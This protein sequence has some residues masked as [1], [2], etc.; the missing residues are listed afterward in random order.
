MNPRPV[1]PPLAAL[2]L[3]GLLGPVLPASGLAADPPV[4][5][6]VG[7]P[8]DP[9]AGTA[10]GAP[11]AP[12]PWSDRTSV[13]A[14][15]DASGAPDALASGTGP[16]GPRP[17]AGRLDAPDLAAHVRRGAALFSRRFTPAD[18]AGRPLAT[19]AIVPTKRRR[20]PRAEYART[21]GLD[22]NACASCHAEPV[23]GGAGDFSANVFVSEGF[24]H[25]DFDTTDPQFSNERNTNHLF[26]AGLVELLAREMSAE[27]Q[28]ARDAA[29][30]GARAAGAPVGA[31]LAAKGVDFGT[32]TAHPDGTLDVGDVDGVDADLVVRP[33]SHKGVMTSLR[34]FTVNALNHHHGVQGVERF[35]ARWTGETDFDEDGRADE[36]G[37]ADVSALVAWQATLGPPVETDEPLPGLDGSARAAWLEA[38]ARGR[39]AF[40]ALGCAGCHRA[41]LPLDSLVFDDP[42]PL[43]AAGTL[44]TGEGTD[45][46]YD[47]ALAAWAATLERDGQGRVLVP[48]FGDLKRH[49]MT[50]NRVAGFGNELLSQRFV[51]RDVFMT[52]ELWGVGSTAPYGHRGDMVTLTEAIDAHGG[53]ARASRDAW[54]A[55]DDGARDDLV[56]WLRTLVIPPDAH[57]TRLVAPPAPTPSAAASSPAS[58]AEPAPS[59]APPM[60]G[61]PGPAPAVDA[62]GTPGSTP[63]STPGRATAD[64]SGDDA[65][66]ARFDGDVPRLV[67]EA[68]PAGIDHVYD[69]P[70]EHF[71]GG[72]VASLDCDG[73]RMPDLFV[74]GGSNPS[75]LYANRSAPG[76]ALAF[77]RVDDEDVA[78]TGVIG[79]YPLDVDADGH[80][81]LVVLRVGENRLLRGGPDCAFEPANAAFGLDGGRAWTTAFAATFEAGL[82][83]PTLAFGNYVD[84]TAPG[85]PWGTCDD[86]VLVRPRSVDGAPRYDEPTLLSPG[87]CALSM[88][89]TDWNRSGADALRVTNDRHYHRDGEEQLWR[90]DAGRYPRLYSRSDGWAP[91]VIW[92]MGIAETDLDADG[93]PEYALTSMGDT[94]LQKLDTVQAD[95]EGRPAYE[96]VAFELG[97]TAH[98]PYAGGDHRPSTGWHAAF[99]DFN[100]DARTDLY[101][102]KGNVEDMGDFA[103]FDPDNLLLGDAGGRF[104]ERGDVAGIAT[105]ARGRGAATVDLNADGLLDLVVVNRGSRA[106]V[107]RNAGMGVPDAAGG[108]PG[109]DA[110]RTRAGGNWLAVELA[111]DGPNPD[112]IGARLSVQTGN[113][114]QARRVSIGGGHASGALG[115]VH[116]GLGVA[117]RATVRVQWPDGEWSAPYR[118]FANR[119]VVLT[120][121]EPRPRQW[122]PPGRA[123]AA[124]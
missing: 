27:L 32:V 115:F 86:N 24:R 1:R 42:G 124:P 73:D 71:V 37:E 30:D 8:V 20:A 112:A 101:I 104:V 23:T 85:S 21:A 94:K 79:A 82:P 50:D 63:G 56:A 108:V 22:A 25:A 91:L 113:H 119:H 49:A 105:E 78:M 14:P 67:D 77:E 2:A 29:L 46:Q 53:D 64:A 109:G 69:G 47:L 48:L 81:D 6:P 7:P 35:G 33:F 74:A 57:L 51:E 61:E 68:R 5:P 44:R 89:F 93:F 17:L 120:R 100:N 75:A 83:G 10:P 28:G 118:V 97:A 72:G 54:A 55:L 107:F 12:P 11:V 99:A 3:A 65:A 87:H 15:S 80:A 114:V 117:E 16:D 43:D 88:L 116:V 98:R 106:A 13:L 96:D 70:W 59:A 31:P 18:G 52:T 95:D 40:D 60:S 103:A 45:L 38:A 111:Q 39:T 4:G 41:T 110:G 36:I 34:Q 122:F 92:G 58:A 19:Q 76:G 26:G 9:A 123:P 121:G 102:A 66:P 90:L 62:A 84:R